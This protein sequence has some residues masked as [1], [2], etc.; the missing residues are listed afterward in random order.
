MGAEGDPTW[1]AEGLTSVS[2]AVPGL[3]CSHV[4][5]ESRFSSIKV[6]LHSVYLK[7]T[8]LGDKRFD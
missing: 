8:S 2:E 7:E 6:K 1:R 4:E 5:W 3:R